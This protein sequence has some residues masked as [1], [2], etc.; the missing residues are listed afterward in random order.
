MQKTEDSL[1][2]VKAMGDYLPLY[3]QFR[4]NIAPQLQTTAVVDGDTFPSHGYDHCVRIF[5]SVNNLLSGHQPFF[6]DVSSEEFFCFGLGVLFHDIIMTVHP[7]LRRT[8]SKDARKYVKVE[9]E[10]VKKSPLALTLKDPLVNAIADI[11][12]AHSDVK[13]DKGKVT[14]KTLE[15]VKEQ[16]RTGD[17][18][19]IRTSILSALLRFGDELDC[20]SARINDYQK[21]VDPAKVKNNPHW[22][23]C[24]LI[25]AIMPVDPARTDIRLNVKELLLQ[26]ELNDNKLNDV[27]LIKE[28][29]DK[30]R[31]SLQ[32]VNQIIFSPQKVDWWHF[33]TV[34]LTEES[35]KI[36]KEIELSDVLSVPIETK[37]SQHGTASS[38]PAI[39][40]AEDTT[41]DNE[42]DGP[43]SADAK[44]GRKLRECVLDNKMLSSGHFWISKER[45]ARDW[46]DTSRLL[47]DKDYLGLVGNS[48]IGILERRDLSP[49]NT[50]IIGE[51]FPGL[52]IASQIGFLGGFGCTYMVDMND[53]NKHEMHSTHPNISEDKK[54]VLVT[55]VV[56]RGATLKKSLEYLNDECE[57][58]PE[59]VAAILAVFYRKPYKEE[60]I[61]SDDIME[62]LLPLNVDFPTELCK[63][64][65]SNCLLH[66][67]KLVEVINEAMF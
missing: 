14:I 12:Y 9:F 19:P 49:A 37:A 29:L 66:N 1:A 25:S 54:I 53:E 41:V 33:N 48:F 2:I 36:I 50:V 46:I 55:D 23:K 57:I 21:L 42:P 20:T 28:V 47:E 59:R 44:M 30:L 61:I 13:D 39:A 58:A 38:E 51:G 3:T 60:V 62:K 5:Q 64:V 18:G 27:I 45:H 11:V 24:E 31:C 8:H 4:D 52:I 26:D 32:E 67:K 40:V 17:D 16:P 56:A 15:E 35:Q 43:C 34:K 22:R 7:K 65:P 6:G 10:N 63:K